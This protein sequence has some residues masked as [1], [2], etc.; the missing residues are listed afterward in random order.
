MTKHLSVILK[1][2]CSMV[3]ADFDKIDF[4]RPNWYE[5]WSWTEK[6]QEQFMDWLEDY[7]MKNK[8][9]RQELLEFSRA[10]RRM[11]KRAIQWF[12]LDYGWRTK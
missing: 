2:M 1:K 6:K 8:E 11:V 10:N 12:I 3:G 9:A 7:L 5:D 4:K